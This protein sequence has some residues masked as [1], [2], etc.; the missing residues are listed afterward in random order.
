MPATGCR[1]VFTREMPWCTPLVMDSTRGVQHTTTFAQWYI[2][3]V[4]Y[5]ISIM[6][7]NRRGMR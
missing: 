1:A 5:D 4:K 6:P 2:S 3:S 7:R